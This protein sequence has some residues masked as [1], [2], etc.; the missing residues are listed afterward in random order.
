MAQVPDEEIS[1]PVKNEDFTYFRK[2]QRMINFQNILEQIQITK[3]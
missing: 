1:F 3:Q 2:I